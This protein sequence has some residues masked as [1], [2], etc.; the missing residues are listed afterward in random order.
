L[1]RPTQELPE[2]EARLLREL[3]QAGPA[4]LPQLRARVAALREAGWALATV[5]APV[6]ANRSTTRMW[7][8]TAKPADVRKNV[9]E[10]GK[11]PAAPPKVR[12]MKVVRLYP[13]VPEAERAELVKLAAQARLVRGHTPQNSPA[14]RAAEEFERRICAYHKRGVPLKRIAE[15][16]G[17]THRAIAA[18][19]ERVEEKHVHQAAS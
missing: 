13:D 16:V 14:R 3:R 6:G 9:K 1:S 18:R 5:G 2:Q 8:L 15:H 19:L 17:V 7:E 4:A 12:T 10:H 11:P